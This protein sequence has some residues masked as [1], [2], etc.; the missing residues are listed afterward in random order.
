VLDLKKCRIRQMWSPT[1]EAYGEGR[2]VELGERI[3]AATID[4]LAVETAGIS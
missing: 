2:E 1:G 3:E 4:R